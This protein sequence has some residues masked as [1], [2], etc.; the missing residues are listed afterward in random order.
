MFI[1]NRYD[2]RGRVYGPCCPEKKP[3]CQLALNRY[4][5]RHNEVLKIIVDATEKRLSLIN[6]GKRPQKRFMSFVRPGQESFYKPKQTTR[7]DENWNGKWEIAADLPGKEK[8]FPIPTAR[9][10][11]I[12]VWCA[13]RK[14]VHLVELT[15]HRSERT[16]DTKSCV[17]NARRRTG[18]QHTC[19]WK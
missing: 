16:T 17:A 1:T 5:W 13:E 15:L 8:F 18:P 14:V 7:T 2:G 12:V 19:L 3:E 10:P 11:D 6:G 4:T 9:K